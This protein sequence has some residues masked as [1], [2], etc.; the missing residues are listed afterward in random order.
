MDPLSAVCNTEALKINTFYFIFCFLLSFFA[1][2]EFIESTDYY[3]VS[4]DSERPANWNMSVTGS[5]GLRTEMGSS[6][7]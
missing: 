3:R 6:M 5:L 4:C 2:L 1:I 7:I